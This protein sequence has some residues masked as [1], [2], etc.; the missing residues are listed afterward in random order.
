[1][2]KR[3]DK[4]CCFRAYIF[5]SLSLCSRVN[6][7]KRGCFSLSAARK[8]PHARETLLLKTVHVFTWPILKVAKIIQSFS[9]KTNIYIE[10]YY[11]S[12]SILRTASLC[13]GISKCKYFPPES[14]NCIFL[15]FFSSP[16]D[17]SKQASLMRSSS[18]WNPQPIN[19]IK[20][21]KCV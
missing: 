16:I 13:Q 14:W 4:V 11:F 6:I 17:S 8:M 20:R 15:A 19:L 9:W 2:E 10:I 1:M 12:T 7:R 18:V 21:Q 5:I 3:K